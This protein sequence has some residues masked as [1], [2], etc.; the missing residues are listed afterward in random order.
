MIRKYYHLLLLLP[1]FIWAIGGKSYISTSKGKDNFT[2]SAAGKSTP[3]FIDSNDYVGVIRALKDLK[4]D[5]G[6]VTS[7]EPSIFYDKLPSQKQIVIVGTLGKS[8]VIDQLIKKGKLDVKG[9]KGKWENFLIQ[10][11][12]KPLPGIDKALVIVGSDKRG[13]IYGIYDVS[14]QIGVSPW[15]FWADVPA[16][17]KEALYVKPIRNIEGPSVKYRGVF[18]NDEAPALTGWIK[19]KYGMAKPS[20]NPP[21]GKNVVNYGREFYATVF[22]LLLRMKA[23]YLWPA[24]WSNAFNED[25][26]ENPRLA[27]EYGIVMGTSHQEPMV[28][29]QQEWDRRYIR[30]L[31]NWD[32]RKH[33]DTLESFWRKGIRRNKNYESIVTMGL[34]GANDSEMKGEMKDNIAMVE[35]IVRNQQKIISE[36]MNTNISEVP[37]AWCLY[38]EIMEY[39]D[40][41]LRVP[42]NITLLWTD[43]NWGNIRRLP[44]EA[45]RKRSGGAGVYY[46]FDYHGDPRSYEWINT[47]PLP[48]IW[49]QMA[50]AKQ[51]GAD[52]IWVV[53][54]GHFKGYELPMEYFMSLGWNTDRWNN[55]N[56]NEFTQLWAT[57]EFGEQYGA[58]I[59]DI[60][61]K[62]GKFNG[63]CKPESLNASTYSL[64]NYNEFET[65][66]ADYNTIKDRAEAIYDKLP[67]EKRDAF[68][69]IVLFPVKACA[70]VNEL[71]LS[72]AKN[73]L[74]ASQKR[75]STNNMA[76]KTRRLFEA[77][78]TLMSHYNHIY[79]D[80]KWNHFMDQTHLGYTDWMP[81][82][83]NS[84]NAIKLD[85]IQIPEEASMGIALES[86]E[87]S[88]PDSNSKATLPQFNVFNNQQHYIE[89]FNKG[90]KPFDY[91]ITTDVPWLTISD[92]Q[93]IIHDTDKR[94]WFK[95]NQQTLPKG[96]TEGTVKITGGG[97]EVLVHINA[98]NPSEDRNK[99]KG[100]V[101]SGGFIA[102]EAE[103][104][105]AN[106]NKGDRKWIR[107]EDYGLTLSGMRATAPA[108]TLA[109]V[110]GKDAPYMEYPVYLFSKDSVE[111]TL[112]T[113]PLLNYMPDR[114]I[115]IAVSF[116]DEAPT[117]ITNV[118]DKFKVHWSNPAWAKTVVKQARQNKATLKI[119]S[120]GAHKLK[121]WMIDP[122]VVVQKIIIDTGGLRQ[123]HLGP[124]ESMFLK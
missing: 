16:N 68:Y 101:E 17:H 14:E 72:A 106:N 10:V 120:P 81:P 118:P 65:V 49:D 85:E 71:Y 27:N 56:I 55:S 61:S 89:V 20:Q 54:V 44:N 21:V 103:H 62:Y 91:T 113:S 38:K 2:L 7:A 99:I 51:Y 59:A 95:L 45:E 4:T 66:V 43:D 77:D 29:S 96:I 15:H 1:S 50:L 22:E 19:E 83:K 94:V 112:V 122:G 82:R 97:R 36:E 88:W 80:G 93:G 67:K 69:Q 115:K 124:N 78:T 23:N 75:S 119:P 28:R 26:P 57:R 42:D 74:H 3:L 32:Y 70:I 108:N 11:I 87:G 13:T 8:P 9:I 18:I 114:D 33:A 25:D 79:A 12:D 30:T 48:K 92:S 58:E 105:S 40:H 86:S 24:M 41:G 60:L 121:V 47:N 73:Q 109:A 76:L 90:S 35:K 110:P 64:I 52:R 53:N 104:F 117:Y 46:H 98:F 5:I 102:I 39:Y 116:D 63:R 100:F 123:S 34:R 107:V 6:K 111:I 31:G 84:L 37:Q